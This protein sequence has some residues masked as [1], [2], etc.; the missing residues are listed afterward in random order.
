[1]GVTFKE[2]SDT[3]KNNKFIPAV[4]ATTKQVLEVSMQHLLSTKPTT[5]AGI[6]M[7]GKC[8]MQYSHTAHITEDCKKMFADSEGNIPLKNQLAVSICDDLMTS[9]HKF[10]GGYLERPNNRQRIQ[11][12]R[13]GSV[14]CYTIK[15]DT[16]T[17]LK[18]LIE[19]M[20]RDSYRVWRV[21]YALNSCFG[22]DKTRVFTA[23]SPD[24]DWMPHPDWLIA[25]NASDR[26][27][28]VWVKHIG[29]EDGPFREMM[30]Q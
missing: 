24:Y 11:L 28:N 23:D 8:V 12:P 21:A 2:L 16:K 19:Q 22:M 25:T 6:S 30:T 7:I 5:A 9:G 10:S 18:G 26:N 13:V 20:H 17:H 4:G 29:L 3:I 14:M 27:F 1:M 15:L